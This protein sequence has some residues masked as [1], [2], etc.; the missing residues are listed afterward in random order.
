MAL[1]SAAI[2]NQVVFNVQCFSDNFHVASHLV[3]FPDTPNPHSYTLRDDLLFAF[4][5][6]SLGLFWGAFAICVDSE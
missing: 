6:G 2:L 5:Y 1:P 3:I 4:A